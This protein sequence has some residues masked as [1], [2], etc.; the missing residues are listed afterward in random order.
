MTIHA[1]DVFWVPSPGRRGTRQGYIVV[2][3]NLPTD[4]YWLP[5]G[6]YTDH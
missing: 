3:G 4:E 5:A 6:L 1:P 2:M